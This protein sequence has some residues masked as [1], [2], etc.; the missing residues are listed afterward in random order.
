MENIPNP[1][2]QGNQGAQNDLSSQNNII[3]TSN[4]SQPRGVSTKIIVISTIAVLGLGLGLYFAYLMFSQSER[5]V[6]APTSVTKSS[7]TQDSLESIKKEDPWEAQPPIKNSLAAEVLTCRNMEI[8]LPNGWNSLQK[9]ENKG[10]DGNGCLTDAQGCLCA[11]K[12]E[13]GK[14]AII[15]ILVTIPPAGVTL[16]NLMES[17]PGVKTDIDKS[18]FLGN[19]A[20]RFIATNKNKVGNLNFFKDNKLF[21]ISLAAEGKAFGVLWPDFLAKTSAIKFK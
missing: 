13:Q 8:P 9:A 12:D 4:S 1:D 16:E 14:S 17:T 6:I 15:S 2:Y 7:V 10:L 11:R 18:D 3:F 19:R 5:V 20:I 21:I